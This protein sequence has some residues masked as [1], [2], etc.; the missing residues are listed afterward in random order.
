MSRTTQVPGI[1]VGR[2]SG[3]KMTQQRSGIENLTM[4]RTRRYFGISTLS[5]TTTMMTP[6]LWTTS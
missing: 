5:T 4:Q 2:D 3:L 1:S 6:L